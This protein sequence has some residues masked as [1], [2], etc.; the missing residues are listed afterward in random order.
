M[1]RNSGLLVAALLQDER[2]RSRCDADEGDLLHIRAVSIAGLQ[3]SLLELA[4]QVADGQLFALR[5][6]KAP[7]EL[8][9]RQ[10]LRVRQNGGHVDI[11][12]L[13]DGYAAFRHRRT[14]GRFR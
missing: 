13:A 4:N 5:A 12:K 9:R 6:G 2:R 10:G 3:P 14:Y 11:G 8:V 7:F 1:K